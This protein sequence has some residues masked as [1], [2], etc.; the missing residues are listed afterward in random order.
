MVTLS[1]TS[2]MEWAQCL[3]GRGS[4][5]CVLIQSE[6]CML[7][8]YHQARPAHYDLRRS[9]LPPFTDKSIAAIT[10]PGHAKPYKEAVYTLSISG[11]IA[12]EL[13][14]RLC[15]IIF[16]TGTNHP[17]AD[18][19][20]WC[21]MKL[22]DLSNLFLLLLLQVFHDGVAGSSQTVLAHNESLDINPISVLSD[23]D[24]LGP[25]RIGTRGMLLL[26]RK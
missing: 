2:V 17:L 25:F 22:C 26:T 10:W 5:N 19:S 15:N 3:L 6:Y 7:S 23:W 14:L 9:A 24:A 20:R 12:E 8:C 21:T 4:L 13:Y 1:V 18:V 11:F 16:Y